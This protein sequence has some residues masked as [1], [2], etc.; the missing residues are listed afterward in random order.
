MSIEKK[1]SFDLGSLTPCLLSGQSTPSTPGPDRV[2]N[3]SF[4]S[5][6]RIPLYVA[7]GV[8]PHH[9]SPFRSSRSTGGSS[10][11]IHDSGYCSNHQF[12]Q[13]NCHNHLVNST[14]QQL[15]NSYRIVPH[16]IHLQHQQHM[17]SHS[18][19]SRK[20]TPSSRRTTPITSG[21]TTPISS[22]C[23][24]PLITHRCVRSV[25]LPAKLPASSNIIET[26]GQTAKS[27]QLANEYMPLC[28]L[29]RAL[30]KGQVLEV[31]LHC[32]RDIIHLPLRS[33]MSS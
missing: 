20:S 11:C 3:N 26:T 17:L 15:I 16:S 1:D 14:Q 32:Q 25:T 19:A 22:H 6:S 2:S 9:S 24:K 21:S 33:F 30:E 18:N 10:T 27:F 8:M 13:R 12:N 5:P 23:H 4:A 31:N 28:E 29:Q 7:N